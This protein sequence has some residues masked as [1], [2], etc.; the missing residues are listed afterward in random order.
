MFIN[1]SRKIQIPLTA[2]DHQPTNQTSY[3]PIFVYYGDKLFASYFD[4]CVGAKINFW[5][6]SL[7]VFIGYVLKEIDKGFARTGSVRYAAVALVCGDSLFVLTL[8]R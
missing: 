2:R 3:Q 1:I 6:M 7:P 8:A 5:C 4:A